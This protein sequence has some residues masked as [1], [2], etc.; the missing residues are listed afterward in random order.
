MEGGDTESKLLCKEVHIPLMMDGIM[1]KNLNANQ[2]YINLNEVI[3]LLDIDNMF[4]RP[5]YL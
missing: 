3:I 4:Q 2:I 1:L 5:Q